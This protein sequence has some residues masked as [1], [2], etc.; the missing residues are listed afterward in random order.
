[1]A[2]TGGTTVASGAVSVNVTIK[3]TDSVEVVSSEEIYERQ[4]ESTP[5]R[6]VR[7][8]WKVESP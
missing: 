3:L 8:V 5:P 4:P 6:F 2:A 1:M 7:W